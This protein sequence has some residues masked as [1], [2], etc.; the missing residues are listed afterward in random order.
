MITWDNYV[1]S[2]AISARAAFCVTRTGRPS[3]M[4]N[5]VNLSSDGCKITWPFC[6]PD[7]RTSA[8]EGR[9][10]VKVIAPFRPGQ[11]VTSSSVQATG[12]IWSVVL[13]MVSGEL[14]VFGVVSGKGGKMVGEGSEET[15]EYLPLRRKITNRPKCVHRRNLRAIWTTILGISWI[16]KGLLLRDV[17]SDCIV[18]L[19][20]SKSRPLPGDFE[21][22]V[23]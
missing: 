6:V 17:S 4:H 19:S 18:I 11:C 7:W 3:R 13:K 14:I 16:T 2:G 20:G 9:L 10:V 22:K 8:V 15:L 1:I 23:T 5:D 21:W 12:N